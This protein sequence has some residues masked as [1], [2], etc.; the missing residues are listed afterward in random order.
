MT[1]SSNQKTSLDDLKTKIDIVAPLIQEGHKVCFE[2][3]KLFL[4]V[5]IALHGGGIL[6]VAN[7][8]IEKAF[9]ECKFFV[10][11][12]ILSLFWHS[13]FVLFEKST[14]EIIEIKKYRFEY[15][16]KK[17]DKS[18]RLMKVYIFTG[19]VISWGLFSYTVGNIFGIVA[20]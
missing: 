6:L 11:G 13:I 7:N 20:I 3:L 14:I 8:N 16:I 15:I 1:V 4:T 18:F 17:L 10:I 19:I 5:S 9:N 12:L 2:H